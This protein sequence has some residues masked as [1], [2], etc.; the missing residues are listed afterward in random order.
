[1]AVGVPGRYLL[2]MRSK[3]FLVICAL[4]AAV[5][6]S[7]ALAVGGCGSSSACTA[8]QPCAPKDGGGEEATTD[9]PLTAD[10]GD[11][12][13][14][15]DA[16]AGE[17]SDAPTCVPDAGPGENGCITASSGV[18]VATTGSDTADAGTMA[19]PY[20]TISYALFALA[21]ADGASS[22]VYVCN[23][24]YTDA[25]GVGQP[26]NVY[27]GM[28]CAGGVWAY[29]T[30]TTASVTGGLTIS[31]GIS[32]GIAIEDMEFDGS[33]AMVVEGTAQ[34]SVAVRADGPTASVVLRRV[35]IVG[36]QGANGANGVDGSTVPNYTQANA[37][38]GNPGTAIAGGLAQTNTCINGSELMVSPPLSNT[39]SGGAGGSLSGDG[40]AGA[41]SFGASSLPPGDTGAAGLTADSCA[42]GG[43]G[44]DGAWGPGGVEGTGA[45]TLGAFIMCTMGCAFPS[46]GGW[47]LQSGTNGGPGEP[48]QGGGG[49]AGTAAGGGGGGGAGGCGG[50]AASGGGSGGAS[51]ALL[52][53]NAPITLDH[54]SIQG[55]AAGQGGA[56]GNGQ[57][58]Q[59]QGTSANG[60]A[61]SCAGGNGG[62]GGGGG[63]G[64]GGAGGL[65][66]AIAYV[67]TL[68]SYGA[69]TTVTAYAVPAQAGMGGMG[70]TS[71][72]TAGAAGS[73]GIAGVA[74]AVMAIPT[75]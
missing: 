25:I 58:G 16:P 53:L 4:V 47:G 15:Q 39:S 50:S 66:V 51:F 68:P 56:G 60:F 63:G 29:Q 32:G 41:P 43:T 17:T 45:T 36:G 74:T 6:G 7:T 18:F 44:Q 12:S 72:G 40:Q 28:T 23:G 13:Q 54:C 55:G 30:G 62:F 73:N 59:G 57:A 26:V 34:S 48:G 61:S 37:P 22:N 10:G 33:A 20:A 3:R 9:G 65:S 24:S 49:G 21:T 69:D 8:A 52:A 5:A 67:G 11:G 75:Q 46:M 1:V 31:A 27:G 35:T 64:G 71:S 2:A 38:N 70:G 19:S 14:A 42:S